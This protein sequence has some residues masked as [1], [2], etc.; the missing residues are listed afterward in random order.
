M[1]PL[2][3]ETIRQTLV[4]QYGVENA[5]AVN[6]AHIS[7]GIIYKAIENI[8]IHEEKEY[9]I[10]LFVQTVRLAQGC[11]LKER[12]EGSEEVAGLGREREK[13]FLKDSQRMIRENFI[14]NFR[15]PHLNYMTLPEINFSSRFS[16]FV[17]EG[18]TEQIMETLEL[19]EQHITQNVN[20]KMVFFDMALRFI[21]LLKQ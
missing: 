16:P 9:G 13:M 2:P 18:N 1:R 12:K 19:A 17:N 20:S 7:N 8:N 6:I 10:T 11:R 3:E 5:Q 15:T 14:R 4:S 21:M